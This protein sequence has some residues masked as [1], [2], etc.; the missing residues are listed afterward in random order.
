MSSPK[1]DPSAYWRANLSLILKLL[2]LWFVAGLGAGILWVE[3][4]NK[5][6]IG[7]FQ[8]GFWM[9]QQGALYVFLLCIGIYVWRMNKLDREFGVDE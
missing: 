9:A 4:L 5:I 6:Q 1:P 8:L 7:G 2:I 3:P